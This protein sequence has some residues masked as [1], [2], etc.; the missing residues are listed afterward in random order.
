MKSRKLLRTEIL[1]AALALAWLAAGT[2]TARA[3]EITLDVSANI[4]AVGS[5]AECGG[6]LNAPGCTLGGFFVI[7]NTTRAVNFSHDVTF[8]RGVARRGP[9]HNGSTALRNWFRTWLSQH[10]SKNHRLCGKPTV[11]GLIHTHGWVCGGIRRR[12]TAPTTP[13]LLHHI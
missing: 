5:L 2:L 4:S 6:M 13:R 12:N 11:L 7:D 3:G 9:F 10:S 8:H 1:V